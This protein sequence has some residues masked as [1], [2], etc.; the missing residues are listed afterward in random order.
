LISKTILLWDISGLGKP[1]H[2]N[3]LDLL[4]GVQKFGSE[5]LFCILSQLIEKYD[6]D[7]E[8]PRENSI[9][10]RVLNRD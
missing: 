3:K 4:F 6:K 9:Y 5:K 8:N 2:S 7:G 1:L 10:A